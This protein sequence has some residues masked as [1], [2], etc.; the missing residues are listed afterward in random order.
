MGGLGITHVPDPITRDA[1]DSGELVVVLPDW[2]PPLPGLML[3]YPGNRH[4][5]STL[6]AFIK[7]L[8]ATGQIA[9]R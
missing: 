9:G 3:Y 6:R 1:L 2:S 7:L 8:K 5:P 4:T